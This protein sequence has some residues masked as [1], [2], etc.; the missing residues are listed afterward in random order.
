[1]GSF[2]PTR[3]AARDVRFDRW[4][5]AA[6][7]APLVAF[8]ALRIAGDAPGWLVA[9]TLFLGAPHVLA[10]LGLY[11]D[12]GMAP[13]IAADRRRYVW[14]PLALIPASALAFWAL[15]GAAAILLVTAFLLWQTQHYTKQNVGVF[16]L[17]C[18]ARGASP[19]DERERALITATT[20]IG[21]LGIL[22]AMELAPT[23]DRWLQGSGLVLSAAM[24][25][26][27]VTPWRGART[28]ALVLAVVFYAPL[29]IFT[30]D[31]LGGAF[32]Y[33][34]AHGAEYYVV[35]G[36]TIRSDRRASRVAIVAVLVGGVIPIALLSSSSFATQPVLFGVAKGIA[37]AHFLAD[38]R[39][40]RLRDPKIRAV[41]GQRLTFLQPAAG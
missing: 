5:A 14:W 19:M 36:R 6:T 10:T 24:L 28:G 16:G 7:L 12:H 18:R 27:A 4:L 17:W 21:V 33:Q 32:L 41:L 8:G 25:L 13:I 34:A 26:V 40:W 22:R 30:T 9:I 31:L 2:A 3:S 38:A 39:L 11:A 1:M 20:A 29:H 23:S 35:V 37:A 15:H